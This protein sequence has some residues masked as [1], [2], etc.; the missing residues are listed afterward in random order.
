[1]T[2]QQEY[3]AWKN[4]P[5]KF[6][7]EQ[8]KKLDW[9]KTPEQA[10]VQNEE[11]QT[12]WFPDGE[13]NTCYLA[14]D[15]HVDNGRADQLALVYDS[16]V[17]ATIERYTFRQL[18]DETAKVAGML[19][20]Q[21]V[22]K[23]DTVIIYMPMIPQAA[24]AMLACAR[25][26]AIHSVVFG[27]FAAPELASRIDDALPKLILTA[28]C[29]IEVDRVI[30]YMPLLDQALDLATHAPTACLVFQREEESAQLKR[31][32]DYDWSALIEIAPSVGCVALNSADPLY[33][34][35]TS[36]TTGKP[37]GVVRDNGGHATALHYSMESIYNTQA[38]E[39]FWSA[40]DVG[41][42]V[43]HSY[44]V[45]APLMRGC[46]TV[47][48]EGK[49]IMTP[50]AGAFW[51]VVEEHKVNTLFS[52]PTAFRAIRRED[53]SASHIR[54]YD[55]SSLERI[56]AA[57]ERL[58]P[59]TQQ[60]MTDSIGVQVFDNWWQ[61]ETGWP[62]C[63]NLS[64]VEVLPIKFGSAAKP[65]PGFEIHVLND[66]GECM[67][68]GQQGNIAIK[69][70]LP[71]SCLNAIWGDRARFQEAYLDQF[72]GYYFSGDGGYFDE[73]GYLFVMGRVDDVINVAG[74]R[75]STGDLEEVIAKHE[76]VAECA[77]IGVA[78]ELKGELPVG[79]AVLSSGQD[80]SLV[81]EQLRQQVRAQIG[82]IA[83]YQ[84]TYV[85]PRLPKTRSGKILRKTLKAIVNQQAYSQPATI[86][87][88]AS[89]AEIEA[90]LKS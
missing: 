80:S 50:D 27:G 65:V 70:P 52:A 40:S 68:P 78:D 30:P 26:G 89:L 44:I 66:L 8:A 19:S 16:P 45:Y 41:W 67:P 53:P 71:P 54:R 61:T 38:A 36:G 37:K 9:Y 74:H 51:R 3:D 56:F 88:P 84:R 83:C 28:S 47:F 31:G 75:L 87:D 11:G 32:R 46:T 14:L 34:L 43:G 10:Y 76:S 6:W 29:G 64:G 5:E 63:S 42:V 12:V 49:P 72:P 60:W 2:Y 85:V 48:Y 22:T 15:H 86:D 7:L 58:D 17:T 35:Y 90:I 21:G 81:A 23:G 1:M 57:G 24:M 69:L 13:L 39:V 18:L 77:V 62:I 73:D 59:A 55:I 79:F 4:A 82:A 25:I 20:Q 33:I